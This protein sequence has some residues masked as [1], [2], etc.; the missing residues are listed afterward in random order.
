MSERGLVRERVRMGGSSVSVAVIT[1]RLLQKF[2]HVVLCGF[3][4]H[5]REMRD[6]IT[7]EGEVFLVRARSTRRAASWV[8]AMAAMTD[9]F[10]FTS[11]EVL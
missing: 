3:V 8:L 1:L 7:L 6:D 9:F 2:K 5:G 4:R 11:D 10:T